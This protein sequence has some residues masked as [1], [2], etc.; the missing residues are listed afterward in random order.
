M[1]EVDPAAPFWVGFEAFN[2]GD[3]LDEC[4]YQRGSDESDMWSEGFRLASN[5]VVGSKSERFD[6]AVFHSGHSE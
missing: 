4:P 2:Q 6:R 3:T 1:A 5:L